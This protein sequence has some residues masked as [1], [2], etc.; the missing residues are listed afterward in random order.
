MLDNTV[1]RALGRNETVIGTMVSGWR[2][3]S[4]A[5]I[6]AHAGFDFMFIDTEHADHNV[7]T[8]SGII[9][10]A[11][12]VGI[13]P[14]VRVPDGDYSSISKPLD[15]G[16]QGIMVPRVETRAEVEAV[17]A[18]VKY[19]PEGIRGCSI[20]MGHTDYA[21]ADAPKLIEHANANTLVIIQIE[22]ETAVENIEELVSV[23]GVDVAFIGP[24]DL[25]VSLGVPGDVEARTVVTA[26]DRVIE[27]CGKHGVAVGVHLGNVEMLRFW[28]R[29][30]MKMLT[31]STDVAML[32]SAASEAL[33]A[34]REAAK[35]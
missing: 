11:R 14:L 4:I 16:A 30:G 23:P 26:I 1:K 13:T 32:R 8:V 15:A 33:T 7:E 9:R 10:M 3:S 20:S 12:Q 22:R 28:M 5:Q 35:E 2:S 21:A 18:A 17:V 24:N 29:K 6:L 19:P 27:A 25:S 34:L 31:Y